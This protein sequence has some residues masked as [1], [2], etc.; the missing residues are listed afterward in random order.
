M[1]AAT[2]ALVLTAT[3]SIA[4]T[5]G[6]RTQFEK[7]SDYRYGP[8][9][10]FTRNDGWAWGGPLSLINTRD[11]GRTWRTVPLPRP[12][13]ISDPSVNGLFF[14]SKSEIWVVLEPKHADH[15]GYGGA[16]YRT[17][18]AG[19]TWQ[20]DQL[21]NE[22]W[23]HQTGM[24]SY[25]R[26]SAVWFGGEKGL[27]SAPRPGQTNR[28]GRVMFACEATIF[29]RATPGGPWIRQ[30]LPTR[31]GCEVRH[32]RFFDA[33]R[34]VAVPDSAIYITE[35]AGAHWTESE[36]KMKKP[37]PL[38]R[39]VEPERP[40]T[41]QFLEG[42]ERIGWLSFEEGDVYKTTDGGKHWRQIVERGQ[43]S[44]G[45]GGFGQWGT[46]YFATEMIGWLLDGGHVYETRDGG[47]HWSRLQGPERL[48]TLAGAGA[49]CWVSGEGSLY[50]LAWR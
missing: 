26:G 3:F 49:T 12:A 19:A 21:P 23:W 10:F 13:H 1:K 4:Q 44:V 45:L 35:D 46:V 31:K 24:A 33:K 2:C 11:G 5:N 14:L 20:E 9:T 25:L 48:T 27:E 16:L 7:L 18:D 36:V 39:D 22:D 50:R 6:E 38:W 47:E 17:L 43:Y 42:D 15:P 28:T 29:H 37:A 30:T 32:I 41:L 40:E 34:G 8:P